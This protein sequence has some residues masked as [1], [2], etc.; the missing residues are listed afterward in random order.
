MQNG[1]ADDEVLSLVDRFCVGRRVRQATRFTVTAN[2]DEA[3]RIIELKGP[4]QRWSTIL[5]RSDRSDAVQESMPIP[6][7]SF[8][9]QVFD[10]ALRVRH[11]SARPSA[12]PGRP[13]HLSHLVVSAAHWTRL[14]AA[15]RSAYRLGLGWMVPA[16]REVL[17]VPRP[18]LHTAEGRNDVLHEDTGKPAAQWVDGS[19]Y[20][21]LQGAPF[22]PDTYAAVIAGNLS[23][24]QIAELSDADQR[25]IALTYLSF[26]NLLAKASA[27]L[28]DRGRKGTT[29]YRIL[30]PARMVED[31]PRGYGMFD[32]FIHMRDASHPEREFVEWVDP[33]IALE[34][35]AEL[36]QAHAFGIT[37]DEW[38]SIEQEG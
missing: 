33:A 27:R 13:W 32:Y 31:R 28:V 3:L 21:F 10:S 36:C 5:G 18:Q 8:E 16:N 35:D 23:L 29:L 17:L 15:L 25:S 2:L 9:R 24:W 4:D 12:R 11:Q 19:G 30:L 34:G 26:E 20:Y 14:S 22:D 7:A 6:T 37:L 1:F 38:L